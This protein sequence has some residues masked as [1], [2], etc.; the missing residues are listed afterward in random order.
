MH[1]HSAHTQCTCTHTHSAHAPT[2]IVYPHS[3]HP[4]SQCTRTHTHNVYAPLV[5]VH[6]HPHSQCT[7]IH[8]VHTHPHSQCICTLTHSARTQCTHTHTHSASAPS[9]TGVRPSAAAPFLLPFPASSS[10]LSF[11]YAFP[12][13]PS[14]FFPF[15]LHSFLPTKLEEDWTLGRWQ[16]L[17]HELGV[18]LFTQTF[19]ICKCCGALQIKMDFWELEGRN[20]PESPRGAV[21]LGDWL[22]C[23]SQKARVGFCGHPKA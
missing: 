18:L 11:P 4:H 7:C 6:T 8:T 14:L 19:L 17:S 2:L 15:P 10:S 1:P 5:T 3:L 23:C 16:E 20:V 22:L 12:C 21:Y 13:L 9:P